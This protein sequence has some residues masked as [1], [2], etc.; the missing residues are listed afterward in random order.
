MPHLTYLNLN[1]CTTGCKRLPGRRWPKMGL[2]RATKVAGDLGRGT[3]R[4]SIPGMKHTSMFFSRKKVCGFLMF[5]LGDFKENIKP[6][7]MG[8]KTW[9]PA[10][11]IEST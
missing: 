10:V 5:S 1:A 3:N 2:Q 11:R 8:E 7:R 4:L 6:I 9:L